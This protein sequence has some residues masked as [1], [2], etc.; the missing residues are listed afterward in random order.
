MV[1]QHLGLKLQLD[2]LMRSASQAAD[3]DGVLTKRGEI[4]GYIQKAFLRH[5]PTTEL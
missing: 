3:H 5:A 2:V 4:Y 1:L